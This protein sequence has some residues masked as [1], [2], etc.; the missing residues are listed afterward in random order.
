[1]KD[2]IDAI[3]G[4][5][6]VARVERLLADLDLLKQLRPADHE[7]LRSE[8]RKRLPREIY[9]AALKMSRTSPEETVFIDDL[10]ENC[11]GARKAGLHAIRYRGARDLKKRLEAL[12]L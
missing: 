9:E 12:G 10:E 11:A 6:A 3:K 1:M 4:G 2:E 5:N 8:I 7:R